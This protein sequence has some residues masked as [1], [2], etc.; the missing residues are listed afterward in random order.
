MLDFTTFVK[1]AEDYFLL[2]I[3]ALVTNILITYLRTKRLKKF[4]KI[5]NLKNLFLFLSFHRV[6]NFILPLKSADIMQL[7]FFKKILIKNIFLNVISL[8]SLTKFLDVL[9]IQILALLI[10]VFFLL[11]GFYVFVYLFLVIYFVFLIYKNNKTLINKFKNHKKKLRILKVK[12]IFVKVYNEI[13]YMFKKDLLIKSFLIAVLNYL[14]IFIII[15]LS[16][17]QTFDKEI[18]LLAFIFSVLQPLP[19]KFFFGIGFF[20]IA[21]YISNFYFGIGIEVQQLF[22]FRFLIFLYS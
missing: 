1:I 19:I 3:F 8:L 4:I 22:V 10:F 5:K 7:F 17:D 6:A 9:L 12:N 18:F 20:D 2:L 16:T 13:D 11:K 14:F 15:Y 21:V